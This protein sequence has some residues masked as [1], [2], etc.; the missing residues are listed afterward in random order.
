MWP[1]REDEERRFTG[2]SEIHKSYQT[3]IV[4]AIALARSP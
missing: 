4:Q 3:S 2:Q 1:R